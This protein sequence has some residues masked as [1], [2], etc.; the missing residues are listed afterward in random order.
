[1]R[2]RLRPRPR[3][4]DAAPHRL[5]EFKAHIQNFFGKTS[6]EVTQKVPK[7]SSRCNNLFLII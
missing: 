4:R 7:H 3:L 2:V 6:S 1:M 5:C